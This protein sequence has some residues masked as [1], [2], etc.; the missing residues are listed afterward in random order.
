[1]TTKHVWWALAIL[2]LLAI[3]KRWPQ[4]QSTDISSRVSAYGP[5]AWRGKLGDGVT[6][7]G[8]TGAWTEA[9]EVGLEGEWV[10]VGA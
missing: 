2:I 8:V 1:M 7:G 9:P 5:P 3:L 6:I 10:R 4:P